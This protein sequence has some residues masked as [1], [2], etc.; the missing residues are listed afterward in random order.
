[1]LVGMFLWDIG[2]PNRS[3]VTVTL[4]SLTEYSITLKVK[5]GSRQLVFLTFLQDV[6]PFQSTHIQNNLIW[7]SRR[8]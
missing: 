5:D 3:T 4:Y 8:R 1:M 2:T 6:L 7:R